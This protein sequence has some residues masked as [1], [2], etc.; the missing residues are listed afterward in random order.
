MAI[1][2]HLGLR[3]SERLRLEILHRHLDEFACMVGTRYRFSLREPKKTRLRSLDRVIKRA[4]DLAET[5]ER[6]LVAMEFYQPDSP[7]NELKR[8]DIKKILEELILKAADQAAQIESA[9]KRGKRWD[10]DVK[11]FHVRTAEILCEFL[12]P[13]FWPSRYVVNHT[14]DDGQFHAIVILLAKPIFP[15]ATNFDRN[16]RAY[17]ALLTS[18]LE[19]MKLANSAGPEALRE[20]MDE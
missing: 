1:C 15:Q 9:S 2:Q 3:P 5:L 19:E 13:N 17:I 4:Q 20:F 8:K 14:E 10:T 6:P 12:C 18:N 7:L 11:D 16:I